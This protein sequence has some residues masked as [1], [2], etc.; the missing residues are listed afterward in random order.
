[1]AGNSHSDVFV[2]ALYKACQ[3]GRY[4]EVYHHVGM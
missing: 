1:V 2:I 3:N 4:F